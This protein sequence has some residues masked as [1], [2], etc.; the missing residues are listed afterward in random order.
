MQTGKGVPMLFIHRSFS[1]V[2]YRGGVVCQNSRNFFMFKK[3]QMD[4]DKYKE[5]LMQPLKKR[6]LCFL[7]KKH[8]VLLG[9]KKKGFGEG[10]WLGIGRKVEVDEDIEEA[11]VR[12]VLEEVSVIPMHFQKS[13][14]LNFY[15]PYEKN[16]DR[17][18]QQM[19]VSITSHWSGHIKE[20]Y[21][22]NSICQYK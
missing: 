1:E 18:N 11:V 22:Q 17:W 19:I 13:A 12:E 21:E 3:K 9:K 14:V 4:I 7:T 16:P 15:F 20:S 8:E 10:K 5:Q 6:T 2:G